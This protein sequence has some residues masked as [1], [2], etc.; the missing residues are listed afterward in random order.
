ML[1]LSCEVRLCELIV[2]LNDLLY[3]VSCTVA[4]LLNCGMLS[5]IGYDIDDKRNHDNC[6]IHGVLK[7]LD[8]T[9]GIDCISKR[10][11][12]IP[13]P[14][15]LRV[16]LSSIKDAGLG[17]FATEVIPKNTKMGPY[18]GVILQE[19]EITPNTDCSYLWEVCTM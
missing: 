14:K 8:E 12:K 4:T 16:K 7:P 17:V 18:K 5:C 10:C 9:L 11:T 19:N 15:Q 6:Q 1:Q 3:G 2:N 13:V